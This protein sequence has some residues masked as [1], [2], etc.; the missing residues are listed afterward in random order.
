MRFA[1]GDGDGDG[2]GDGSM[3]GRRDTE[4]AG[5]PG[6]RRSNGLAAGGAH[7]RGSGG[8]GTL[9]PRLNHAFDLTHASN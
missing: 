2:D 9:R 6:R 4:E 3:C 1:A 8:R 7:H 5:E